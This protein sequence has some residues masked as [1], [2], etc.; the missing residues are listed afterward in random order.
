MKVTRRTDVDEEVDEDEL[1]AA[2][3]AA[4]ERVQKTGSKD[5]ADYVE[6]QREVLHEFGMVMSDEMN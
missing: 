6:A 5:S 3:F 1:K 4:Y 2:L